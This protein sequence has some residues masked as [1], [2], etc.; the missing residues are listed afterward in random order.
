MRGGSLNDR[1][2]PADA[3]VEHL[4]RLGLSRP[5]APLNWQQRIHILRQ[6]AEGLV[7]LHTAVPGKG[8]VVHRDFKPENVRQAASNHKPTLV[9]KCGVSTFPF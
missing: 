1:I 4:H 6:A 8:C 5:L 7:Y 3:S 9:P 2:R